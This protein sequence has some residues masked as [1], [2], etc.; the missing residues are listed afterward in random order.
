MPDFPNIP[1]SPELESALLLKLAAE[2]KDLEEAARIKMAEARKA[3]AYAESQEI[4]L[5]ASRRSEEITLAGD[6]F[7]KRYAF[8]DEVHERSVDHLLSQL[9]IW[10]RLEPECDMTI[11]MDSP[12]GSVTDGMHLFDEMVSLSKRGGGQHFLTVK[13]RGLAASMAS[14]LLQAADDRVC[15]PEAQIMVHEVSSWAQG[16]HGALQDVMK[17]LDL[18]SERVVRIFAERSGGKT[19]EEDFKKLW[20]RKDAWLDSDEALRLGFIDRIG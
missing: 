13:V 12:G 10:D 14:I 9:H 18:L 7:A 11:I 19:T 2:T 6:Y 5:R 3:E 1:L 20:S 17:R 4:S 15:G 16:S 8:I